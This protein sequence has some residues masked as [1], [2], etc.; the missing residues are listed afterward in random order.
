MCNLSVELLKTIDDNWLAEFNVLRRYENIDGFMKRDSGKIHLIILGGEYATQSVQ[1]SNIE[2]IFNCKYKNCAGRLRLFGQGEMIFSVLAKKSLTKFTVEVLE[3][4]SCSFNE[5][6]VNTVTYLDILRKHIIKNNE[7]TLNSW[8]GFYLYRKGGG[9]KNMINAPMVIYDHFFMPDPIDTE[10]SYCE[11]NLKLRC[12]YKGKFKCNV[13]AF[14]YTRNM[15]TCRIL[16]KSATNSKEIAKKYFFKCVVNDEIENL[17]KPCAQPIYMMNRTNVLGKG[18][19]HIIPGL[20]AFVMALAWTDKYNEYD[21]L[22]NEEIQREC[23][24][25]PSQSFFDSNSEDDN[26]S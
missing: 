3:L 8:T 9:N 25:R 5:R 4:H 18:L 26:M 2:H 15:Y 19:R 1:K 10:F 23:T 14:I 6:Q 21:E 16:S 17:N 11:N 24:N 7:N 22:C 13:Q 20:D 12:G